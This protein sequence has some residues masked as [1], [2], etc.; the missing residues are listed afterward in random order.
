MSCSGPGQREGLDK[1]Y[2]F[3]QSETAAVCPHPHPRPFAL[4]RPVLWSLRSEGR[5]VGGEDL[6][7]PWHLLPLCVLEGRMTTRDNG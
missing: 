1:A 5:K 7:L 6:A 3:T 2:E 4:E